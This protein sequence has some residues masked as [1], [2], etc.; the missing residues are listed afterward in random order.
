M[1]KEITDFLRKIVFGES[2]SGGEPPPENWVLCFEISERAE[3]EILLEGLGEAGIDFFHELE[4]KPVWEPFPH[5]V[6][7]VYVREG[8]VGEVKEM[9]KRK[10]I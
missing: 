6:D 9:F 10:R 4:N 1:L 2:S 8:D 5:S 7:K 3:V